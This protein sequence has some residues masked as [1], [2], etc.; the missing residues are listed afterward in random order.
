MARS[1]PAISAEKPTIGAPAARTS[2]DDVGAAAPR[3]RALSPTTSSIS[4][5]IRRR[6]SSWV[7]RAGSMPGYWSRTSRNRPADHRQACEIG[8]REQGGAQPVIEVVCVIGDIVRDR[9]DLRFGAR[10]APEREIEGRVEVGDALRH[11]ALAIF[12]GRLALGVG[13]R[14]VV[15]DDPFERF[16]GQVQ[17]VEAGIAPLH[18]GHDAQG[19]GIVVEAAEVREAGIERPLAGVPERRVAEVMGERRAPR[20]GPRRAPSVRA[21]ARAIWVTSRVWVRRVR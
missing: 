2:S 10:V 21:S 14:P 17:P 6:T 3:R 15:L 19:L 11:A 16:P 18:R 20:R 9:R 12:A 4:L 1:V 7:S 8:E 5:P 13:Q